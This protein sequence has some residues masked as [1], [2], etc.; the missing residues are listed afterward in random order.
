MGAIKCEGLL[1]S[2]SASEWVLVRSLSVLLGG[3]LLV[4]EA[5]GLTNMASSSESGTM[6][7]LELTHPRR[8]AP[9]RLRSLLVAPHLGSSSKTVTRWFVKLTN[10]RMYLTSED[11]SLSI[12]S[13]IFCHSSA[14]SNQ[15]LAFSIE[16]RVVSAS[17]S[18]PLTKFKNVRQVKETWGEPRT[19]PERGAKRRVSCRMFLMRGATYMHTRRFAP[20]WA[21]SSNI[22]SF[23]P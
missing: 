21:S 13:A 15:S 10:P 5:G 16:N 17:P 12:F 3:T 23:S 18:V 8:F 11:E 20:R 14:S 1:F 9:R 6:L 2:R 19:K 4:G 7:S 22:K